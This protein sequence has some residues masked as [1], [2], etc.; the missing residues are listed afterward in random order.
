MK[1]AKGREDGTKSVDNIL[2]CTGC[3]HKRIQGVTLGCP[4]DATGG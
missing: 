2:L 4:F 1:V 3:Q